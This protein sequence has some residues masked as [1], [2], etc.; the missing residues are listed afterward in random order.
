[1]TGYLTLLRTPS[2]TKERGGGGVALDQSSGNEDNWHFIYANRIRI[3]CGD[4]ANGV[5]GDD[6]DED[7]DKRGNTVAV[8]KVLMRSRRLP[9]IAVMPT[10]ATPTPADERF[11]KRTQPMKFGLD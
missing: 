1:M 7:N 4:D 3:D 11:P 5:Y 6:E 2:G 9:L 8:I 10:A